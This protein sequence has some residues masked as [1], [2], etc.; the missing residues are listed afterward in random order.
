MCDLLPLNT[1]RLFAQVDFANQQSMRDELAFEGDQR[2]EVNN[3]CHRNKAHRKHLNTLHKKFVLKLQCENLAR[4]S[5]KAFVFRY[6]GNSMTNS[7]GLIFPGLEL[8]LWA[9]A[10]VI[11]GVRE[12]SLHRCVHPRCYP[13]VSQHQQSRLSGNRVPLRLPLPHHP[14]ENILLFIEYMQNI[15]LTHPVD[16]WL[17]IKITSAT[18]LKQ[19]KTKGNSKKPICLYRSLVIFLSV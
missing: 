10:G 9:M 12:V 1:S 6:F 5:W 4:I 7:S 11:L 13:V 3:N 15:S 14:P 8:L 19:M 17:E 16:H 2:S 18:S